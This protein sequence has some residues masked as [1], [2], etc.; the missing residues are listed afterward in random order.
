MGCADAEGEEAG[1]RKI[2]FDCVVRCGG[3]IKLFKPTRSFSLPSLCPTLE[4]SKRPSILVARRRGLLLTVSRCVVLCCEYIKRVKRLT[5]L[6]CCVYC[7]LGRRVRSGM[8]EKEGVGGGKSHI[9]YDR[10]VR[11]RAAAG[12][13]ATAR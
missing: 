13:L 10:V 9:F 12:A 1:P 2:D 7:G 11:F 8:E 5:K 3:R 4:T 6:N